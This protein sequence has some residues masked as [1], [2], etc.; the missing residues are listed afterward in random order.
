MLNNLCTVFKQ[1]TKAHLRLNPAKCSLF[2]R[3]TSFLGHGMSER[4]VST[5]P[6]KVEAVE[7]WPSL[8]STGEVHSFLG[9]ASYYWRFITGFANIARPL[10]QLTEKGQ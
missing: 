2:C 10:H 9:L 7:K 8:T 5:D 6:S 4:G 3:Q 1:I